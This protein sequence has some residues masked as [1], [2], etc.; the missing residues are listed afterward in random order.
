MGKIISVNVQTGKNYYGYH[1]ITVQYDESPEFKRYC[2]EEH[3]RR[4]LSP[5]WGKF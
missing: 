4:R 5:N 1:S 3:I 2:S